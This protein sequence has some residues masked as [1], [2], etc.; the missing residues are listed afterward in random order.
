MA[1]Q[2]VVEERQRLDADI[3]RQ[4]R[5]VLRKIA[6]EAELVLDVDDPP[7]AE[8]L[9]LGVERIQ[10]AAR[11][12]TSELRRQVGL[13]RQIGDDELAVAEQ[14]PQPVKAGVKRF[15][16]VL[17][18]ALAAFA[19]L[20]T[21]V[22]S[23]MAGVDPSVVMLL[24]TALAASLV[25]WR[26]TAPRSAAVALAVCFIVAWAVGQH[27]S[28]GFWCLATMGGLL[29][30]V[31]ADQRRWAGRY[32][33]G[34][35]IVALIGTVSWLADRDNAVMIVVIAAAGWLGGVLAGRARSR[36]EAANADSASRQAALERAAQLAV[37][38]ERRAFA[39]EIHDVVSHAV[40]VIA[41]QASAAEVLLTSDPTGAAR[42]LR[43]IADTA[44]RSLT[45]MERGLPT[46]AQTG[47][48]SAHDIHALPEVGMCRTRVD[49]PL[50]GLSPQSV[51]LRVTRWR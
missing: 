7:D 30:A 17:G 8:K 44:R 43:V 22:Y 37:A 25:M 14:Q 40:G 41:V 19:T 51:V 48:W 50:S 33:L 6:D 20:E 42:S 21:V 29:W 47:Q 38:A 49:R 10:A 34:P 4:L 3:T 32:L 23:R 1:R 36:A 13:V 2:A 12:A 15:D 26:R 39:R 46:G 45:E 24:I 9:A 35:I 31:G 27:V 5:T 11:R 16:V 28:G 18:V